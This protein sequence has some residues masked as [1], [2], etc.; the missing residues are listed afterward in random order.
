MSDKNR[1]LE[2]ALKRHDAVRQNAS[3]GFRRIGDLPQEIQD[4]IRQRA[5]VGEAAG[6]QLAR[7]L[8]KFGPY[9]PHRRIVSLSKPLRGLS[10]FFC[11][12]DGI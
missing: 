11:G 1:K 5:R 12:P 8:F 7:K 4:E 9:D 3:T 6:R 10:S 2:E